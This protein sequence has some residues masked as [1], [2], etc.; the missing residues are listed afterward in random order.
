MS[1]K[2]FSSG[3]SRHDQMKAS[4]GTAADDAGLGPTTWKGSSPGAK[5]Y[6]YGLRGEKSGRSKE[7]HS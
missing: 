7:N 6:R 1:R 5:S 3:G 2:L 4:A